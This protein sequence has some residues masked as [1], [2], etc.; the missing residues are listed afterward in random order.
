MWKVGVTFSLPEKAWSNFSTG[1]KA[2]DQ[3]S[4]HRGLLPCVTQ[5]PATAPCVQLL[6]LYDIRSAVQGF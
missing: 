2:A 6:P 5:S 1:E 4:G 3:D